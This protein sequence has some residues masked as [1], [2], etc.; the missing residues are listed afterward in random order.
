[1]KHAAALF[2]IAIIAAVLLTA[3]AYLYPGPY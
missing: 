2:G 3:L 1:M